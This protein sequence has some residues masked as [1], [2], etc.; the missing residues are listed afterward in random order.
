VE[1]ERTNLGVGLKLLADMNISPHTVVFL[2]NLGHDVV[3]VNEVL[4]ASASDQSIV[5]LAR[6]DARVILTQD[7]DFSALIALTGSKHPSAITLRLSSSR[8]P[9]VNQL[10]EKLLPHLEVD[11]ESGCLIT[12]E[13][14]GFRRRSL[15][16]T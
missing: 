14:H 13:D 10:L 9:T 16:I 3:R 6:I 7:L 8:V 15:P 5:E 11:A 2:R 1:R 12:I 4:P